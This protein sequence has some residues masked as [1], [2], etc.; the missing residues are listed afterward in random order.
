[1]GILDIIPKMALKRNMTKDDMVEF[2]DKELL[3]QVELEIG[4]WIH[5]RKRQGGYFVVTRQILCMVDFLGAVYSGYTKSEKKRDQK[6]GIERIAKT[7]KAKNYIAKFF[8]PNSTYN[9]VAIDNLYD[10]YRHGLVHVYQPRVLKFNSRRALQWFF[11]RGQ[12]RF[13][14]RMAVDTPQGKKVFRDVGYLQVVF[15]SPSKKYY[16]FPIGIDC[17]YKDFV[18]SVKLYRDKLK[19][20]KSLQR[21]WRTTV[22]AICKPR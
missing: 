4:N 15:K 17:L 7:E 10:I 3:P 20:T 5:P 6:D 12:K 13:Y 19:S 18:N 1:V 14:K 11:Y 21:R 22:N 9:K 16:F 8:K 2:I